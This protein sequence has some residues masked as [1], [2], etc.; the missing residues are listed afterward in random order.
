MVVFA[1]VHKHQVS[2]GG[3]YVS[4]YTRYN[5]PMKSIKIFQETETDA[6]DRKRLRMKSL[7]V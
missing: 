2:I 3:G 1:D 5:V 7:Y 4:F 6:Y